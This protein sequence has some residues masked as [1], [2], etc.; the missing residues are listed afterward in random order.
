MPDSFSKVLKSIKAHPLVNPRISYEDYILLDLSIRN[1]ELSEVNLSSSDDLETYIWNYMKRK[2]AQVAYGGYLE[3]RDIYRRSGYFNQANPETERNIH[4]GLD[5]WTDAESPIYAPLEGEIHSFQNNMNYGD[6]GPTIILKH[7]FE[8]VQFYSLYGHLSLLSIQD[9]II[10]T[11]IKK[12]QQ[13]AALGTSEVNGA[14]P[15]H[16]HFQ[17]IKELQAYYGDYPG[18]SNQ[19]ELE[20]YRSNCPDP[21]LLLGI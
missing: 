18:V 9:K 6:Y 13:I 17:I 5:F 12:G 2:N 14:Y 7:S 1:N 20:F 21:N 10:G 19:S 16:L 11:S 3:H 4:L 8:D 15:P